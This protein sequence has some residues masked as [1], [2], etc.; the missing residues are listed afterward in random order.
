MDIVGDNQRGWGREFQMIRQGL[1]KLWRQAWEV[2]SR[3]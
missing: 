3:R 1:E 2:V